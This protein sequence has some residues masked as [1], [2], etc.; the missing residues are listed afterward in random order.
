VSYHIV[1]TGLKLAILIPQSPKYRDYRHVP[2]HLV[3]QLLLINT[4]EPDYKISEGRLEV[5]LGLQV[6]S[7]G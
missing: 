4:H 7:N 5:V 3:R 6:L 2:L 1:Q